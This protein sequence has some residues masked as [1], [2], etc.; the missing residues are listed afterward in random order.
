MTS[1]GNTVVIGHLP[2]YRTLFEE[3][4][5]K[6]WSEDVNS[7]LSRYG[8]FHSPTSGDSHRAPLDPES[9]PRSCSLINQINDWINEWNGASAAHGTIRVRCRVKSRRIRAAKSWFRRTQRRW[10]TQT[11]GA[12]LR[13]FFSQGS[14]S[15][16]PSGSGHLMPDGK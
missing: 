16:H 10:Q 7:R 15:C 4:G 5:Y 11:S 2:W 6:P 14:F 8:E 12:G 13:R 1:D 9:P 3:H